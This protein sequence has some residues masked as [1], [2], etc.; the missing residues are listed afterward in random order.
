MTNKRATNLHR[1]G[2][3]GESAIVARP[4]IAAVTDT[5]T[6]QPCEVCTAKYGHVIYHDDL[7][8]V[9][10]LEVC[11]FAEPCPDCDN[12]VCNCQDCNGVCK[13]CGG[14]GKW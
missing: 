5:A 7:R 8:P 6:K 12:G 9:G 3:F 4:N 1:A 11:E 10:P 2:A 13:V 14:T